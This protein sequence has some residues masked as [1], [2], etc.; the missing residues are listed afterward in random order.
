MLGN[1]VSKYSGPKEVHL[2]FFF[3]GTALQDIIISGVIS[4]NFGDR[5]VRPTII[6][7]NDKDNEHEY[8]VYVKKID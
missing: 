6:K 7:I 2:F 4:I 1:S 8:S 5:W 3:A